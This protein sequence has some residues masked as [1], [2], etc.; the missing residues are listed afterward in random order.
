[1]PS[2]YMAYAGHINPSNHIRAGK[3]IC[4]EEDCADCFP[5]RAQDDGPDYGPDDDIGDAEI[6]DGPL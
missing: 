5:V 3:C 4:G 1:M 6:S 2:K